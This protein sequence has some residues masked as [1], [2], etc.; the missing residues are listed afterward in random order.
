[1]SNQMPSTKNINTILIVV[2]IVLIVF[3]IAVI[4]QSNIIYNDSLAL[5]NKVITNYKASLGQSPNYS[6]VREGYAQAITYFTLAI[7]CI[8]VI[9]LLPRISTL[10]I[11]PTGVNVA[12][13]ALQQ[14][15]NSLTA[16]NNGMASSSAGT[17]G[18]PSGPAAVALSDKL[19]TK[20]GSFQIT[21]LLPA[22][23]DPQ[24]GQWGGKSENNFRRLSATVVASSV[25]GLF[26]VTVKVEST[27][28]SL[29]PLTGVV[30]FHLHPSF[31]N[32]NPMIT[33]QG[34]IAL[35][36]LK[37]VLGHFTLGA[38]TDAGK[39]LLELDL[40]TLVNNPKGF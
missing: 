21:N 17:G 9:L 11:G 25:P 19:A 32:P 4:V 31:D 5:T 3:G 23:A 13:Q 7:G 34:G 8:I 28:T 37:K 39:N 1:M 2:C 36:E 40:A 29:L 27:D 10:S 6:G 20:A 30:K 24:K 26:K 33:V 22:N 15:I 14:N 12:L 18:I 38:E 35:L 16:Q